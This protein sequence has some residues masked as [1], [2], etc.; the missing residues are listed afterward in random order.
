M[1]AE[2]NLDEYSDPLSYDAENDTFEPDGSFYLTLAQR[3]GGEALEIG[4]GTGRI[5][6]PLAEKGIQITGLDMVPGMLARAKSKSQHV[7]IQWIEGDA[8]TFNLGKQFRF[9]F[10]AGVPFQHLLERPDQEAMLARVSEHLAPD[11][12]FVMSTIF[13]QPDRLQNQ[14]TEQPWFSFVN[15]QGQEVTVTGT[16]HYNPLTQIKTETAY[17]R[18]HDAQG[19]E[20]LHKAPLTLRYFHPQ[21]MEALLHYNGF[22]ITERYGDS[23]F[24]PLTSESSHMLYVC[25]KRDR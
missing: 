23:D 17:R 15:E 14:D 9:I 2:I 25:R 4:C 24:S 20:H 1:T 18:W 22:E 13:P 7:S 8:R 19:N 5:T 6:I 21:E 3:I 11:G 16:D 12:R 10:G